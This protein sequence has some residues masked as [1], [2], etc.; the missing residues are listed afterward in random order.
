MFYMQDDATQLCAILLKTIQR[1]K[2]AVHSYADNI[3]V[4]VPQLLVLQN[5]Y[6]GNRIMGV[7]A[8]SMHCD[9]SN[10]TGIVDRLESQG[11]IQRQI[12]SADRRAKELCITPSGRQL[13]NRLMSSLP[14]A[15]GINQRYT[16]SELQQLNTLLS[17]VGDDT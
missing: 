13:I 1:Y 2:A 11:Y 6:D 10:I 3:G 9:A 4:T 7:V 15:L 17:K 12:S 16:T 5:L 14:D 8:K